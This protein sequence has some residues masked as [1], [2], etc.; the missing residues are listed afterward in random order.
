MIDGLSVSTDGF[1]VEEDEYNPLANITYGLVK[2][3][4]RI[5]RTISRYDKLANIIGRHDTLANILSR[6]NTKNIEPD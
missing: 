2:I 3:Y 5:I 4:M 6:H 1:V